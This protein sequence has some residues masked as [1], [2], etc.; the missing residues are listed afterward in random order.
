MSNT[1]TKLNSFPYRFW[2][3]GLLAALVCWLLLPGTS[4]DAK[5]DSTV[6]NTYT[7][8]V[9]SG[10]LALRTDPSY[11][12][13][14]EIG[15]LYSGDMVQVI[16]YSGDPYW[17]VYSPKYGE[18][19]YVNCDYLYWYESGPELAEDEFVVHVSCGYLA[20]RTERA[21]DA[22]NEIGKLQDEDIVELVDSDDG[23]YW[24]VYAPTLDQYGYVNHHYLY[25]SLDADYYETRLVQVS[26]GYLALRTAQS[27]DSRN[28]IGKLYT[29][30]TVQIIDDPNT[31]YWYVYSPKYDRYGYVNHDYLATLY[32][33]RTVS[34]ASG[35]LALR[36]E[37]AYDYANE[38]GK[39]YTG[40]TVEVIDTSDSAYWYV[41]SKKLNKYG[42]VNKKYLK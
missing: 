21:F 18:Y 14:N 3:L 36:T 20:L 32:P 13:R 15:K 41:Y 25:G 29:G 11:D 9:D 35:Y 39:L 16:E 7:V 22:S 38:I 37:K 23:T 6:Y 42:Y 8:S 24:Y 10:Y 1:K 4:F 17:Y 40:D 34:V 5:A 26:S 30:D 27:F 19:G 28:E 31:T 33:V 12:S 2:S